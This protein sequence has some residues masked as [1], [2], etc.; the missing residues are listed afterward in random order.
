MIGAHLSLIFCQIQYLLQKLN[1]Y[2]LLLLLTF[3][4]TSCWIFDFLVLIHCGVAI[5]VTH[6]GQV[7]APPA[8]Q[9]NLL[10]RKRRMYRRHTRYISR[11]RP[12]KKRKK[13]LC[14]NSQAVSR[15]EWASIRAPLPHWHDLLSCF[16][17]PP[18]VNTRA[19]AF[20]IL[21]TK[22]ILSLPP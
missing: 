9:I 17:V 13:P 4:Q 3:P 12:G 21:N 10:R 2:T 5:A 7:P 1:F 11:R 15:D 6:V 22:Q 19:D 20:D 14:H 18:R 16:R 8:T